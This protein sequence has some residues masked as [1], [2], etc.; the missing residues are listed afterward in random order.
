[1]TRYLYAVA[2]DSSINVNATKAQQPARCGPWNRRA[3][4]KGQFTSHSQASHKDS[5]YLRFDAN[6]F[7]LS[8]SAAISSPLIM[9]RRP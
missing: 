8:E 1:M 7:A 4:G 6:V 2:S 5:S 3:S 9:T